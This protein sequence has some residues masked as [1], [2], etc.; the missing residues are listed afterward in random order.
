MSS[1]FGYHSTL[2]RRIKHMVSH[3]SW[4]TPRLK[5]NDRTLTFPDL[6]RE[7]KFIF[8]CSRCKS[9]WTP[10]WSRR[11]SPWPRSSCQSRPPA[12][13]Q[14]GARCGIRSTSYWHRIPNKIERSTINLPSLGKK[15]QQQNVFLFLQTKGTDMDLIYRDILRNHERPN[16]PSVSS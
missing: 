16:V 10:S 13:L 8:C 6:F 1:E 15:S 9:S 5:G 11:S 12:Q 7:T 14:R 2:T 3:S 4:L